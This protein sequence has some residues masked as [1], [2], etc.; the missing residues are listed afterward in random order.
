[1]KINMRYFLIVLL[2]CFTTGIPAEEICEIDR[3]SVVE[4]VVK[5]FQ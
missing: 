1:M 4:R 2:L 5:R 3:A